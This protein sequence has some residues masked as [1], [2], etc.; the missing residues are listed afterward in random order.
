MNQMG[1]RQFS[2]TVTIPPVCAAALVAGEG[3]VR[4]IMIDCSHGNAQKDVRNQAI[5]CRDVLQQV[6]R[7]RGGP[8][9]GVLLESHLLEGRQDWKPGGTLRFG[10]SITDP[11]MGWEETTAL[12]A[13]AANTVRAAR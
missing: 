4:P 13:D 3:I 2:S 12:L 6:R 11:C 5:A 8:I 1:R 9:M 10:Q 7:Q